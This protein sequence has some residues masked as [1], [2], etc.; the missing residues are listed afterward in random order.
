MEADNGMTSPT[1][2]LARLRELLAAAGL[3]SPVPITLH[4]DPALMCTVGIMSAGDGVEARFYTEETALLAQAA[5]DNLPALL[6]ALE[7]AQA[8]AERYRIELR[9]KGNDLLNVRGLLSPNGY[10]RR[11]PM[12][13]GEAVA[14]AVE[15]LL[16]QLEELRHEVFVLTN[17][18]DGRLVLLQSE[19]NRT[20]SELDQLKADGGDR[21]VQQLVDETRLRS[22]E[23]RNGTAVMEMDTAR[24]LTAGFVAAARTMLGN[25]PN[26]TET[27]VALDVKVAESPELYTLV[28]QRHAPGALTPHEARL[29]AESDRDMY[30]DRYFAVQEVLDGALGPNEEEGAGEGIAADVLLLAQ[31]RDEARR[32]LAE[33]ESAVVELAPAPAPAVPVPTAVPSAV[34]ADTAFDAFKRRILD[35]NDQVFEGSWAATKRIIAAH[36]AANV[37]L[38]FTDVKGSEDNPYLGEHPDTYRFIRESADQFGV[39]LVW[40]TDGRNIWDVFYQHGWLGNSS[41]SHCSWELKTE[42]ARRWLADNRD[43]ADTVVVLGMDWTEGDRHGPAHAAYAHTLDGCAAPKKCRGRFTN[44]GRIPG[45]G[46]ENLLAVPWRV[47][48]PMNERPYLA[49]PQ[50]FDLMRQDGIRPSDMYRLGFAHANCVGCVKGGHT[51]WRRVLEVMPDYYADAERREL[52]F[53]ASKPTRANVS[54]L[55]DRSGGE[56][57]PITLREFRERVEA[58][59]VGMLD[60]EFDW[61]G[62]GCPSPAAPVMAGA[63]A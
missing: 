21:F 42:P 57:R 29:K 60:L 49:S 20:K 55:K 40:L 18:E 53:R 6:T 34:V 9:D 12:E 15:W 26:Y 27:R 51:H 63:A 23:F 59:Q 38:L 25:A 54:I 44:D 4:Y 62:C 3:E 19:L 33:L 28:V 2:D 58:G 39:E 45:P 5:L 41:L 17:S 50:V 30:R 24:E 31:Q 47:S 22:M 48:M 7:Q 10:P 61:G 16:A 35:T 32:K 43:P 36:G 14:P 37:T 8:K 13:I 46:C 56:A 11:V 1:P 52:E